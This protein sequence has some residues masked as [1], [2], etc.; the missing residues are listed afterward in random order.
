MVARSAIEPLTAL[1]EADRNGSSVRVQ[2]RTGSG[3]SANVEMPRAAI[4]FVVHALR[5]MADGREIALVVSDAELTTQQAAD[6]MRVS[7]PYLVKLLESGRMPHRKVGSHRRVLVRDVQRYLAAERARRER[8]MQ[9]LVAE[10]E[11]LG[12]YK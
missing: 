4:S 7:R 8:V 10:T 12:L 6:M 3:A 11:R 1:L 5:E 9:D 2:V